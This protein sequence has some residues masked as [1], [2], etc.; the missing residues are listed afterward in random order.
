MKKIGNQK[1]TQSYILPYKKTS[2]KQ[3]IDLYNS[4]GRKAQKWQ[5]NMLK[6][7]FVG[8]GFS[9][10][11]GPEVEYD[12]YNFEALNLPKNHPA[13]DTQDTFYIT[14]EMFWKE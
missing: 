3:A 14:E 4:T 10:V 11:E 5:E 1:P 2:G 6:D 13:R 7:I 8:M 9:I 12:Y